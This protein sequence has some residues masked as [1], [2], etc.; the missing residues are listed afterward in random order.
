MVT[1][2]GCARCRA[3]V[4]ETGVRCAT[5]RAVALIWVAWRLRKTGMFIY[6]PRCRGRRRQD[7]PRLASR[8]G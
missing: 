2:A 6:R 8:A 4:S 3:T 7:I 1:A 5:A